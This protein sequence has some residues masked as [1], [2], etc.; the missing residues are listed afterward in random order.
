MLHTSVLLIILCVVGS[1]THCFLHYGTNSFLGR[2]GLLEQ[3]ICII[4]AS[5]TVTKLPSE[6]ASDDISD[7]KIE[8]RSKS[9]N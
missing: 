8:F 2:Y 5:F 4:G 1:F 9:E 7:L 6:S 3:C